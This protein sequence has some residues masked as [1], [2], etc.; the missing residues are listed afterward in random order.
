L[1]FSFLGIASN[2]DP[3]Y[4]AIFIKSLRIRAGSTANVILF[5]VPP[6][7]ERTLDLA[8]T[9][10]ILLI[11]YNVNTLSPSFLKTYHPSSLRWI[12]FDDLFY[13]NSA[14]FSSSY[15]KILTLD[16]RDSA[17][18]SDPFATFSYH[19]DS[20][21]SSS[22]K[23][24]V[25]GETQ[26]NMIGS[27]GWN[28]GWIKDCFGDA[29]L[30][31][32]TNN[33]IICSG[34][35]LGNFYAIS[36]YIETMRNFLIGNY[37][38]ERNEKNPYSL[39]P[40][41]ERNGVDQGLHNYIIYNK[42]VQAS[43]ISSS[44]SSSFIISPSEIEKKM[45][46]E[47]SGKKEEEGKVE[48]ESEKIEVSIEFPETFPII[49]LQA[50]I[51]SYLPSTVGS[52]E[53]EGNIYMLSTQLT[54]DGR[55]GPRLPF[56]IVHQYDRNYEYQ[57]ILA[58]QYIDWIPWKDSTGS[59]LLADWEETK[60]CSFYSYKEEVDL[61]KGQCDVAA[62]R[63]MTISGCCETC[64]QRRQSSDPSGTASCTGFTYVKGICYLKNCLI[65][66]I[67]GSVSELDKML[68]N[69]PSAVRSSP[70]YQEGTITAYYSTKS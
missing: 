49:N 62:V 1:L 56:S 69:N 19:N 16:I 65:E 43:A 5:V 21:S 63:V 39:F 37:P 8:L 70:Y 60:A 46:A 42:L 38:N 68:I 15:Q 4:L 29:E 26:Y 13:T 47:E 14:F 32:I 33:A 61:L 30:N 22:S 66:H 3:K 35:V 28:S 41:C 57:M 50:N 54:Q 34:I 12:L 10:S 44:S 31:K 18:Q 64:Q 7:D 59:S 11:P 58:K 20:I 55:E 36:K 6:I 2:I 52:K 45:A 40:T 67:T 25:F 48:K 51:D 24:Y 17:F 27:C 9:Y 53:E 23:L